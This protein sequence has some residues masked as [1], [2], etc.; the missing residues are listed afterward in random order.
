MKNL[1]NIKV[2][3]IDIDKTLTNDNKKVTQKNSLAIKKAVEKGIMVVL[4]SG[5]SFS[6]AGMKAKE[7]NASEYLITSNGAQIYDYN[8]SKSLYENPISKDTFAK[9]FNELRKMNIECILNTSTTRFGT[10][11]LKRKIDKSESFF[12]NIND[13]GNENILQIVVEASSFELMDKLIA[14]IKKYEDLV[15]LNLSR[16]YLENNRNESDYYADINNFTVNKG[17]GIKKFLEMFNIKK[18][19]SLC[20]GDYVNDLDMFDACGF[21]V[22]MENASEELKKKADF[23]TLSNNNSGVAYFINKYIINN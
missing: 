8:N 16:K 5:R 3:F 6:Y 4:C 12:E 22:A 2:I 13:I 20:F 7:A 19:D 14:E 1:N 11:N 15:V 17:E 23:I 18:E 21:K 10:K 9:L